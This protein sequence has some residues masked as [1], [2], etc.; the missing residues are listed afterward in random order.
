MMELLIAEMSHLLL[1][2]SMKL[3]YRSHRKFHYDFYIL[4][5]EATFVT[6]DTRFSQ[7]LKFIS[8]KIPSVSDTIIA[9]CHEMNITLLVIYKNRYEQRC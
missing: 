1:Y 4:T 9:K 3:G 5:L 6:C 2:N 8:R 7:C